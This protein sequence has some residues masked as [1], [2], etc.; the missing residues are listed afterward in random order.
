MIEAQAPGLEAPA[1]CPPVRFEAPGAS[2]ATNPPAFGVWLSSVYADLSGKFPPPPQAEDDSA[3]KG[4]LAVSS[5]TRLFRFAPYK[6]TVEKGLTYMTH[7]AGRSHFGGRPVARS[8]MVR[9][10]FEESGLVYE[11][12]RKLSGMLSALTSRGAI[13]RVTR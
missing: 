12:K 8:E 2:P 5:D 1:P 13:E 9:Y 11:N 3:P 6:F 4:R 7:C 10:L